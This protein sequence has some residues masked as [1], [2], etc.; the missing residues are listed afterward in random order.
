MD[1]EETQQFL[2]L[3]TRLH[4]KEVRN[5]ADRVDRLLADDFVEFTK[6][7]LVV[8]KAATIRRLGAESLDRKIAVEDFKARY[9]CEDLVLVTYRSTSTDPVTSETV[10]TLRSSIW[11]KEGDAWRMTFH[12]GTRCVD[13]NDAESPS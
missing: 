7:G 11:R 8:D 13:A 12:Q 10:F 3:E 5:A 6:S 9:L 4:R 1:E 2:T